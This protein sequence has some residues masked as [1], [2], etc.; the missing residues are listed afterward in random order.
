MTTPSKSA[1]GLTVEQIRAAVKQ[2]KT[3]EP[4]CMQRIHWF[5]S[6]GHHSK[7]YGHRQR[8]AAKKRREYAN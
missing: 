7:F 4:M 8:L 1:L 3:N 6:T 5:D 2:L